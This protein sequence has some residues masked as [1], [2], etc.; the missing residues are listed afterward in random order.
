MEEQLKR[1]TFKKLKLDNL[2]PLSREV[3][4][5]LEEWIK[6]ELT[7]ASNA[8]EGNTLTRIETAEV[9]EKGIAAV[10]G[11]P[12]KDQLEA[13][14][15]ARA[16]DYIQTLAKQHKSH[17]NIQEKDI[18]T[19]HRLILNGINDEWAGRYRHSEVFVRGSTYQF[20]L[21]QSVP[22]A[23]GELMQWLEKVRCEHPVR[24]A[25]DAHFKLVTVHPFVDGNGRTARLLMNLILLIHDYPMAVIRSEERAA[26][27]DAVSRGQLKGDLQPLYAFAG[28]AAERTLD[29]WLAAA[30][31]KPALEPFV[32]SAS[33]EGEQLLKIGE[34]AQ[35]AGETVHTLRYWTKE[36]LLKVSDHT[37]GGYQLYE[38]EMV[39]RAKQVRYLQNS[40]RLTLREIR[41]QLDKAA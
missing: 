4:Q 15:H 12:L 14:N 30:Q 3:E 39:E 28:Q 20:P 31:G 1:L 34:L 37:E 40:K 13:L 16:V 10:V 29:A 11:K 24:I 38:P 5:Q 26:Y 6:V 27:L 22:Y 19:I 35:A 21:P 25:A 36:G 33:S 7:Y 41:Q 18:L 17:Q 8:I 32:S 2:R 9:L 23:M